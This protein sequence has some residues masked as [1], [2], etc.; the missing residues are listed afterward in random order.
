M[1]VAE[2]RTILRV[3]SESTDDEIQML[4]EAAIEDMRR[5]G[6]ADEVIENETPLVRQAIACYCKSC[7]GFDNAEADRFNR[8]YRQI[9]CDL[10]NSSANIASR[11]K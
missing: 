5:V 1:E 4:I 6:I 7:Y 3:S 8:S 11:D 10:L 9:V 2:I